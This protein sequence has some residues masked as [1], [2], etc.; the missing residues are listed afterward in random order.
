[1]L[2]HYAHMIRR[3]GTT[4]GYNMEATEG[5]Q[6]DLGKN[7]YR[8][9]NKKD[10]IKQMTEAL[11]W[12]E[13]MTLYKSYM[14]WQSIEDEAFKKYLEDVSPKDVMRTPQNAILLSLKLNLQ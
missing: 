5:L 3:M 6:I 12:H 9:L 14:Q 13:Q 2:Q 8:A 10:Y 4:D 1:M 11:Q 7:L